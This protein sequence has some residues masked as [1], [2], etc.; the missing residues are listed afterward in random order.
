MA[1]PRPDSALSARQRFALVLVLVVAMAAFCAVLWKSQRRNVPLTRAEQVT[2]TE[3]QTLPPVS[4][5]EQ[6]T[7]AAKSAKKKKN[8]E[9]KQK[10]KP[11]RKRGKSRQAG[12]PAAPPRDIT[13]ETVSPQ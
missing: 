7:T 9:K 1:S 13:S 4:A 12:K 5:P 6:D 3:F 2:I 10:Q 8:Q 11:A